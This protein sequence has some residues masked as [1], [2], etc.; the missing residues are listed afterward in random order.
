MA[1]SGNL[2]PVHDPAESWWFLCLRFVLGLFL[3]SEEKELY[4][5]GPWGHKQKKGARLFLGIVW[6]KE[7]PQGHPLVGPPGGETP[8]LAALGSGAGGLRWELSPA[9]PD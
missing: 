3:C 4:S 5:M 7:V 9:L 8:S 2:L 1:K 6:F